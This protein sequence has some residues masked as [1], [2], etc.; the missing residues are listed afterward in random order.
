MDNAEVAGLGYL[1]E[2]MFRQL[3]GSE[4]YSREDIIR[5]GDLDMLVTI[6]YPY[7]DNK[8]KPVL[9]VENPV[10]FPPSICFRSDDPEKKILLYLSGPYGSEEYWTAM[11]YT[12]REPSMSPNT[13]FYIGIAVKYEDHPPNIEKYLE[14]LLATGRI[15][16]N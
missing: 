10:R 14:T 15:S 4:F 16:K 8:I 11:G 12:H 13:T 9:S 5:I 3:V 1:T 2:E 6:F 7:E